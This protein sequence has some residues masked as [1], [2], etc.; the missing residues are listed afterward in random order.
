MRGYLQSSN[1]T[2]TPL[3]KSADA[4]CGKMTEDKLWFEYKMKKS[5]QAKGRADF[6]I[7]A[8]CQDPCGQLASTG[9]IL[10]MKNV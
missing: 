6:K 7:C 4:A 10:I 5:I 8:S 2:V 3:G 1:E 9:V